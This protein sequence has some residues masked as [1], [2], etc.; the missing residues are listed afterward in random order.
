MTDHQTIHT[1]KTYILEAQH[2]ERPDTWV[3]IGN[4]G[5]YTDDLNYNSFAE[6]LKDCVPALEEANRNRK[7]WGNT[8]EFLRCRVVRKETI[9]T[10]TI[11]SQDE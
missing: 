1:H 8:R 6:A 5:A 11:L 2:P 3:G 9:T 10:L 4:S 7:L